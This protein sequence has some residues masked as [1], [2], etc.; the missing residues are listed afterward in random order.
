MPRAGAEPGHGGP[1]TGG[2]VL[3]YTPP[4]IIEVRA[5]SA[6]F[7]NSLNWVRKGA[8]FNKGPKPQGVSGTVWRLQ[9]RLW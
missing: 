4:E 6:G 3:P 2:P 8:Q 1:R 9:Y 5:D 7:F